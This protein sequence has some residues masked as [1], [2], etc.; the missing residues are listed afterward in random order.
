MPGHGGFVSAY[1]R[2]CVSQEC[3]RQDGLRRSGREKD[4][5]GPGI[6]SVVGW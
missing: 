1:P 3:P 4:S 6:L 5:L 2:G